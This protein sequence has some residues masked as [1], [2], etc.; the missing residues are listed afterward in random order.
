MQRDFCKY[1][2]KFI[3]MIVRRIN[4]EGI[5]DKR[6]KIKQFFEECIYFKVLFFIGKRNENN[7]YYYFKEQLKLI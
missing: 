2:E 6:R 3:K 5:D 4:G 1:R 7:I